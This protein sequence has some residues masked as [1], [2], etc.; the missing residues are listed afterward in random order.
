MKDRCKGSTYKGAAAVA[1]AL[2]SVSAGHEPGREIK[3]TL[4]I[5]LARAAYRLGVLFGNLVALAPIH[6]IKACVNYR[7]RFLHPVTH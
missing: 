5:G 1:R 2:A 4:S 7:I 6:I 3:L